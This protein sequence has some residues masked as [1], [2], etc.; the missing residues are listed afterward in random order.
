MQLCD[1]IHQRPGDA[2]EEHWWY[3]RTEDELNETLDRFEQTISRFGEALRVKRE[4]Q[5]VLRQDP[6]AF[7]QSLLNRLR[8][9]LNERRPSL[10]SLTQ[11]V[12]DIKSHLNR[13]KEGHS[14]N[15][16][17]A[18]AVFPAARAGC[19]A[20]ANGAG[21]LL[22]D[23]LVTRA[24]SICDK[25]ANAP[26]LP[27]QWADVLNPLQARLREMLSAHGVSRDELAPVVERIERHLESMNRMPPGKY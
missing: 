26:V 22:I 25:L 7:L 17:P 18:P 19:T 3:K 13:L 27:R 10:D 4:L 12:N 15:P 2:G 20:G 6:R 24:V 16:A 23:P 21:F 1:F 8:Y 11:L 5:T 9:L 14:P